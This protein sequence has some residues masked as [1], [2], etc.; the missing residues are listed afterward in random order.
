MNSWEA[1]LTFKIHGSSRIGADGIG[2]WYKKGSEF[3]GDKAFGG[4]GS[5]TGLLI[6]LDTFDNTNGRNSPKIIGLFNDGSQEYNAGDNGKSLTIGSCAPNFRGRKYELFVS[7]DSDMKRLD[8]KHKPAETAGAPKEC[9]SA[10]V[11]LPPGYFFG[12]SAATGGLSDN[13][14]VTQFTVTDYSTSEFVDMGNNVPVERNEKIKNS[15]KNLFEGKLDNPVDRYRNG[16][17]EKIENLEVQI[18][19]ILANEENK[20]KKVR[21][22]VVEKVQSAIKERAHAMLDDAN[23]KEDVKKVNDYKNKIAKMEDTVKYL[24]ES[25]NTL[26]KSFANAQQENIGRIKSKSSHTFIIFIVAVQVVV[27]YIFF[28][29]KNVQKKSDDN[30]LGFY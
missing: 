2:L 4:P 5:W 11:D 14:D 26:S 13:H 24:S 28:S 22:E 16:K 10:N 3:T 1:K 30:Y 23:Y 9:F 29:W 12:M 17:Y 19:H 27:G 15:R 8:V 25:M 7:Y 20:I 21:R 6:A 18:G